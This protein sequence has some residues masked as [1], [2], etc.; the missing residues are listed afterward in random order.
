MAKDEPGRAIGREIA[1]GD[2]ADKEL[3]RFIERRHELHEARRRREVR[4]GWY[5]WHAHHAELYA[6]LTAEHA[7]TAEGLMEETDERRTA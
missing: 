4:A 3:N 6:R 5:S 1:P 7:A 2:A